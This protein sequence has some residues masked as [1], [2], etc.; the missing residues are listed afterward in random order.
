MVAITVPLAGPGYRPDPDEAKGDGSMKKI[1]LLA[2]LALLL[3]PAV[4]AM[5]Q[6][7]AA[8]A[9]GFYVIPPGN[10]GLVIGACIGVGLVVIGAARGVGA[11]GSHA[12][13][14][15]ARQPEAGGRVFTSMIISAALIEGFTLFAVVVCLLAVLAL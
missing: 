2:L 10:A 5:A 9:G 8:P 14:A 3:L 15:I 1:G 4:P 6:Q 11:I 12:V 7:A 13:D